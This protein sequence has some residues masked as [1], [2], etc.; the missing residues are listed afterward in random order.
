MPLKPGKSNETISKNIETVMHEW[1]K[2]G[3]IGTSHPK[4]K[5]QAVKQAA[6]IAYDKAGRSRNKD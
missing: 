5:K 2:D 3:A 4:S 1:K 6:A